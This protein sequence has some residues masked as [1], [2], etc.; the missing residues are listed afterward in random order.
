ML[1][2]LPALFALPVPD[3]FLDLLY[4]IHCITSFRSVLLGGIGVGPGDLLLP[5]VVLSDPAIPATG[6][7]SLTHTIRGSLRELLALVQLLGV[8]LMWML[9]GEANPIACIA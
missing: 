6:G 7:V 3:R 9:V 8:V 4:R 2:L 5:P 1:H